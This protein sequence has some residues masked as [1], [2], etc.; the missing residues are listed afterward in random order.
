MFK[1]NNNDTILN[2]LVFKKITNRKIANIFSLTYSLI[3]SFLVS[4]R[5][6]LSK[7]GIIVI[8]FFRNSRFAIL[9]R[10]GFMPAGTFCEISLEFSNCLGYRENKQLREYPNNAKDDCQE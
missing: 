10:T 5:I 6:C 3:H 2:E 9:N 7:T 4:K 1:V 8:I